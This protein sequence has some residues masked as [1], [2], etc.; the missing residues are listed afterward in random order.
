MATL[1]TVVDVDARDGFL[2][3]AGKSPGVGESN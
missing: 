1:E 3:A 2:Q